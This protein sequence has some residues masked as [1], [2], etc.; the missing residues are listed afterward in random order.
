VNDILIGRNDTA[1]VELNPHLGNRHGMI[2][3]ATGTL[4]GI[5][6]DRK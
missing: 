3:G 1:A 4:G 5:F 6:G 2:A